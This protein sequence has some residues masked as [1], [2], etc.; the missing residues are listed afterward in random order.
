MPTGEEVEQWNV[1]VER[2]KVESKVEEML[3]Y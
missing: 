1:K 3:E 2:L